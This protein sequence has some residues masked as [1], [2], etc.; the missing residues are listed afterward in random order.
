MPS[1]LNP[2]EVAAVVSQL[3][4]DVA[5]LKRQARQPTELVKLVSELRS[6]VAS[7]KQEVRDA[8]AGM[9]QKKPKKSKP[10][11]ATSDPTSAQD[12][13][14]STDSPSDE[15]APPVRDA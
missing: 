5:F 8:M 3:R 12:T 6:D 11:G 9:E 14:E 4:T 10:A 15:I 7:L 2:I 1:L 13:A